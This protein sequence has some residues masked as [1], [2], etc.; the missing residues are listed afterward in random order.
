MRSS[1]HVVKSN[2]NMKPFL[3]G[4]TLQGVLFLGTGLNNA[5]MAAPL[6]K[7][8]GVKL[9]RQQ[10]SP[11]EVRFVLSWKRVVGATSYRVFKSVSGSAFPAKPL[12]VTTATSLAVA[13]PPRGQKHLFVV[14]AVRGRRE[15]GASP[16]VA[17]FTAPAPIN[18]SLAGVSGPAARIAAPENPIA[19]LP[20]APVQAPL[21]PATGMY[22]LTTRGENPMAVD[23]LGYGN[24]NEAKVIGFA[25]GRTSNQRW[26]V[27]RQADGAYKIRAFSGQNSRMVLEVFGSNP[28]PGKVASLYEDNNSV[29][30]RWYFLHVGED[31]YRIIP[32]DS[33]PDID[34]TLQIRA[35]KNGE[36]MEVAPFDGSNHQLFRLEDFGPVKPRSS[37]YRIMPRNHPEIA[38]AARKTARGLTI[39]MEPTGNAQE[40]R[41]RFDQLEDGSYKISIGENQTLDVADG[42]PFNRMPARI[43]QNNNSP[44]QM[45]FL[46][47]VAGGY[48]RIIPK[49]G[50]LDSDQTLQV[51]GDFDGSRGGGVEIFPYAGTDNQVFQL[52]DLDAFKKK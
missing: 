3:L 31:C 39:G 11:G 42:A 18:V 7:P 19:S 21:Q 40:Q 45:W 13:R 6:A 9:S 35:G 48:F 50:V 41:W 29:A 1:Q 28:Q 8:S 49:G 24:F 14:K 27:E 44:A 47:E 26:L 16:A 22:R 51:I 10:V 17:L 37:N 32:K 15:S 5:V 25:P 2:Q 46:E 43:W 38:L 34:L 20:P 4:I 36:T 23:V 12:A 52:E 33:P 30:Q